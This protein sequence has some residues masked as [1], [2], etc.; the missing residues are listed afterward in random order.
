MEG[1]TMATILTSI[2][3]VFTQVVTW[4]G[5]VLGLIA[6]NPILLL[7]CVALVIVGFVVGWVSRLFRTN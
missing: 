6:S 2:G 4:A 3:A 5:E 1:V 7:L